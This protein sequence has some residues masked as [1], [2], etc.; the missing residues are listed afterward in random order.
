MATAQQLGQFQDPYN[1]T[2]PGTQADHDKY[3]PFNDGGEQPINPNAI[4]ARISDWLGITNYQSE[5]NQWMLKNEQDYERAA[6]NS[7]RA[8]EDYLD[9]TKYQRMKADLEK[10]GM[11]P[12]LALQNGASAS[13]SG[14]TSSTGGSHTSKS[15]SK[16][17]GGRDALIGLASIAKIIALLLG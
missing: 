3:D 4:G 7:A 6:I 10:A 1:Y 9:S 16:G 14:A 13:A 17:T 2:T 15:L 8:W 11:N 12:W 5:Y